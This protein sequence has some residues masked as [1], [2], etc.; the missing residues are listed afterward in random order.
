M[1]GCNGCKHRFSKDYC[2]C[3]V[4]WDKFEGVNLE[5]NP[6]V[7]IDRELNLLAKAGLNSLFGCSKTDMRI[8]K[9]IFNTPATVVIW[10]DGTK[11]IVKAGYGDIY[12]PEKGL[13]MAIAKKAL[14]NK[15]NYYE[16]FKKWLPEEEFEYLCERNKLNQAIDKCFGCPDDT[17]G[18]TVTNDDILFE[19]S[20]GSK[21][22]FKD[23]ALKINGNKK[24]IT[25]ESTEPVCQSLPLRDYCALKNLTKNKVY[26]MIERGEI[27]AHKNERGYWLIDICE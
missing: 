1:R 14:G 12:D 11:S 20:D 10:K 7:D 27:K 8:E 18:I 17:V 2:E 19:Q 23:I 25:G 6:K 24:E 3:C 16:I 15:G 4:G 21:I 22:G 13:A 9:V 26:G 5:F